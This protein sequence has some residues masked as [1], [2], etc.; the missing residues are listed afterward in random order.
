MKLKFNGMKLESIEF[1]TLKDQAN[2]KGGYSNVPSTCG[3][4]GQVFPNI[5]ACHANCGGEC[6]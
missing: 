3:R 5:W 1:L 2:L 4:T 6:V